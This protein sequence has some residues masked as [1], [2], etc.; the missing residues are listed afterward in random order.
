MTELP[1]RFRMH[2]WVITYYNYHRLEYQKIIITSDECHRTLLMMS[3]HWFRQWPGAD[4]Q[5]AITWANVDSDRCC[6]MASLGHNELTGVL[7]W[8]LPIPG[9]FYLQMLTEFRTMT[10]NYIHSSIWDV[11]TYAYLI[12]NSCLAKPSLKLGHMWVIA[13]HPLM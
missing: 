11:T 12:I 3:Q 2:G 6:L 5:Q 10:R 1:I 9:S 13:S 4:R 7:A 8:C